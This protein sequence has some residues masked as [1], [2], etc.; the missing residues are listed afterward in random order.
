MRQFVACIGRHGARRAQVVACLMQ[1][2]FD[3][4]YNLAG[5]VYAGSTQVDAS[6]PRH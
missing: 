5:G 4:V 6:V 3:D 1:Q 2:G